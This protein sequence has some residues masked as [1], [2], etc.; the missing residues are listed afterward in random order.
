MIAALNASVHGQDPVRSINSIQCDT[1]LSF[2][3][4]PLMFNW[5]SNVHP[6]LT[7][8]TNLKFWIFT[9]TS[10]SYHLSFIKKILTFLPKMFKWFKD[11]RPFLTTIILRMLL[12]ANEPSGPKIVQ[13]GIFGAFCHVIFSVYKR[14]ISKDFCDEKG[15]YISL[16]NIVYHQMSWQCLGNDILL[17]DVITNLWWPH[18][19]K[20]QPRP[21]PT[22]FRK[23]FAHNAN[24][25]TSAPNS[26]L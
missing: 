22:T 24:A 2:A 20:I 6:S 16:V 1:S 8:S 13:T 4:M 23:F 14:F 19:V 9:N 26:E 25:A 7:T 5:F 12:I 3:T 17:A 18:D 21:T 15:L 11:I 10:I